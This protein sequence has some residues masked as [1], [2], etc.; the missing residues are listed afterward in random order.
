M[1]DLPRE[2]C[3]PPAH[4][5]I[6]YKCKFNKDHRTIWGHCTSIEGTDSIVEGVTLDTPPRHGLCAK[7]FDRPEM[8][9][10]ANITNLS[11]S[12]E[13]TTSDFSK[14]C[15]LLLSEANVD[16]LAYTGRA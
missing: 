14:L 13:R 11:E 10:K 15:S 5:F 12:Q 3:K 9:P 7:I 8:N 6:K 1:V 2:Q 4:G 16:E